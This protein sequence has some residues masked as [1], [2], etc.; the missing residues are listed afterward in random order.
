LA[1]VSLF[2]GASFFLDIAMAWALQSFI[3]SLA[4]AKFLEGRHMDD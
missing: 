3:V 1:L 2:T 4:L